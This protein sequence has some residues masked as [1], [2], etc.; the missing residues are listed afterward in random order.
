MIAVGNRGNANPHKVRRILPNLSTAF[1][2]IYLK[3]GR[4]IS[5][6]RIVMVSRFLHVDNMLISVKNLRITLRITWG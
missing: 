6:L 5:F 4:Q 2:N 3:K 1:N